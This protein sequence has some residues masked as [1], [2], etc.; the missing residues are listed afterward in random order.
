MAKLWL[1]KK[2]LFIAALV[3]T[4]MLASTSMI[5]YAGESEVSQEEAQRLVALRAKGIAIN[6]T[7]EEKT[8]AP[9]ALDLLVR[10][11]TPNES[12]IPLKVLKGRVKVGEM[13]YNVTGGRGIV[14]LPRR[15]ALLRLTAEDEDGEGVVFKFAIR[16]RHVACAI[17]RVKIVGVL[18]AEEGR[19]FLL[20]KG[21][22]KVF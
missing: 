4:L 6:R 8:R 19:I 21:Y 17:Y 10:L 2:A 1:R 7:D 9:A 3:V 20:L 18:K 5:S 13:V 14:F 22:A 12:R 11:G 16:Y 15:L